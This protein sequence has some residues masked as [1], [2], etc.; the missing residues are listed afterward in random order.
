MKE[1][2]IKNSQYL[3]IITNE[4]NEILDGHHRWRI[5]N[6]LDIKPKIMVKKFPDKLAEKIFVIDCNLKRRHLNNFQ[7]IELALKLKPILQEIA[8]K[9]QK[10]GIP[11]TESSERLGRQGVNEAIG[12][13]AKVGHDNVRKVEY[14][15]KRASEVD[16][17]K[18]NIGQ[19]SIN[20]IFKTLKNEEIRQKMINSKP[21]IDLPEGCKLLNGD[22]MKMSKQIPDNSVDLI[23]TDP[24][25]DNVKKSIEIFRKLGHLAE[26][27]LKEGGSLVTFAGRQD[28]PKFINALLE[29]SKLKWHWL[30]CVK[31]S[32]HNTQIYQRK[33]FV[34]WKPLLWLIKGE[35]INEYVKSFNDFIASSPTKKSYHKWQQSTVEADY[36]IKNL[37]LPNQTV[38]DPFMGSGTF[39]VAAKLLN[40][41]F[42]GI[43]KDRN[44]F[45]IARNRIFHPII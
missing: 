38:F 44:V 1:S 7:R 6:E 27:V 10:A 37:T 20:E 9:N 18:L 12:K 42:V 8:N 45:K 17:Q 2:I 19:A 34:S 43:E 30:I 28:L 41:Q 11:L 16:I 32:G 25:Y 22:F 39:G 24:P 5:L 23:L 15:L 26:R 13:H 14:I 21:L 40:R 31:H 4:S 3:P 35:K 29:S 36:I 33:I